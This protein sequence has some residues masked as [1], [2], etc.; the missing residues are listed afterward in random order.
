[1]AESVNAGTI[2]NRTIRLANGL[3]SIARKSFVPCQHHSGGRG[4][5]GRLGWR[6]LEELPSPAREK[7]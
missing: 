7:L 5:S 1:M 6:L 2:R 3:N 4:T